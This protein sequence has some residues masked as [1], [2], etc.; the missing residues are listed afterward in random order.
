MILRPLS[1]LQKLFVV[2]EINS[3]RQ[4]DGLRRS[5]HLRGKLYGIENINSFWYLGKK[6]NTIYKLIGWHILFK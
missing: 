6:E 4:S 2:E 1:L 5:V 3:R